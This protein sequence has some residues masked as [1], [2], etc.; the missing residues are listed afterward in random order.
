M[1]IRNRALREAMKQVPPEV[2]RANLAGCGLTEEEKQSLLEH[3][4]GA[5]LIRISGE[6]HLSDRTLDRRRATAMNKLRSAL[7]T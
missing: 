7:E 6:M 4:D 1:E 2:L 5:D 3:A